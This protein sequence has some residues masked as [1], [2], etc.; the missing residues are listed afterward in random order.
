MSRLAG[1]PP[2]AAAE[3]GGGASVGTVVDGNFTPCLDLAKEVGRAGAA[4]MPTGSCCEALVRL[5]ATAEGSS[6]VRLKAGKARPADWSCGTLDGLSAAVL[7]ALVIGLTAGKLDRV[8]AVLLSGV[9][10]AAAD[11]RS[12]GVA[13]TRG[14]ACDRAIRVGRAAIK[15]VEGGAGV[16]TRRVGLEAATLAAGLSGV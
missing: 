13:A 4:A 3:V 7:T 1:V 2:A 11:A 8:H 14:A 16:C 5:S 9:T 6:A 10:W 15:S 12:I